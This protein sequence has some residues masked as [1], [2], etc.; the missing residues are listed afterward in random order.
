MP[1]EIQEAARVA[2][3]QFRNDP[4]HPSLHLKQ[5]HPSQPIYSARISL[6]Y[7]ALALRDGETFVW[8]WIGSHS[9]YDKLIK[10]G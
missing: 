4:A 9:D 5:V 2:Y 7:R 3:R 6:Q 1:T 10:R 8:F